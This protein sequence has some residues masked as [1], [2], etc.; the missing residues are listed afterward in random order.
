MFID[1]LAFYSLYLHDKKLKKKER[2][3]QIIIVIIGVRRHSL[4]RQ[5]FKDFNIL[6]VPFIS[7]PT[8]LYLKLQIEKVEQ[9]STIYNRNT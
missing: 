6:P 1:I 9:N 5:I 2:C 8:Y 4:H 7:I 3:T